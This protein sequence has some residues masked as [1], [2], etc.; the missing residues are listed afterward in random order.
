MMY[1]PLSMPK[2]VDHEARRSAIAAAAC[3]VIGEGGLAAATMRDIAA[4]AGCTTGMV[5]HYFRNKEELLLAALGS[6]SQAVAD[7]VA[8][9]LAVPT[10]D[11]YDLLCE[12]LPLDDRRR[13]E[14][15]VWIAFWDTA[16]R[17]PDLAAE[18]RA[19]Y[20]T[21]REA[22]HLALATC[23]HPPQAA[24]EEAAEALMV[25][26]DGIG[27]QAVFDTERWPPERQESQMRKQVGHI[28]D[29]LAAPRQ[30]RGR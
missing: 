30:P 22:L 7:R 29:E 6:A 14:W 1:S 10:A 3:R 2:I 11:L 17:Q 18:Q 21:W 15:R 16:V 5:L 19:R 28:L 27:I 4:E 9:R 13:L 25:V 20:R 23:G 26:I 24:L 8:A 12:C